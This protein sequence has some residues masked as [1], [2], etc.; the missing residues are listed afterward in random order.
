[1]SAIDVNEE[2]GFFVGQA[3]SKHCM[4]EI[5][6]AWYGKK[7]IPLWLFWQILHYDKLRLVWMMWM[8]WSHFFIFTEKKKYF[9]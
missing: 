3:E 4:P 2:W 1:M 7:K 9:D 8:I 6:A 5:I